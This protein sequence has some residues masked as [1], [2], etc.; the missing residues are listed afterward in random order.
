MKP[1]VKRG[2]SDA[3][4]AEAICEAV[5]RPTMGFVAI[6]TVEQQA[7]PSLHR[8]RD[9]LVR[10]LTQRINVLRGLV[11]EFGIDL[12]KGLA[13]VTGFAENVTLGEVL[14]L[15]GTANEVICNQS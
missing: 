15:P 11:A 6:K 7:L 4:D 14:N 5:T 13:R 9:L 3:V 1:H 8:A 10:Q 12:P 2:K